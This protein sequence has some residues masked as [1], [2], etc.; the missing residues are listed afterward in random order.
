MNNEK[1]YFHKGVLCR[2]L[3]VVV[4]VVVYDCQ[5]SPSDWKVLHGSSCCKL[6]SWGVC[7]YFLFCCFFFLKCKI[8]NGCIPLVLVLGSVT[9]TP[10]IVVGTTAVPR[11]ILFWVCSYVLAPGLAWWTQVLWSSFCAVFYAHIFE[12]SKNRPFALL[13]DWLWDCVCVYNGGACISD[14]SSWV[15]ILDRF[16]DDWLVSDPFCY[17][18][19]TN[20]WFLLDRFIKILAVF[21]YFANVWLLK[22]VSATFLSC[23]VFVGMFVACARWK[24]LLL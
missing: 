7:F 10:T 3:S 24:W 2:L 22:T 16:F 9:I 11:A 15:I 5:R 4:V 18:P 21:A 8:V 13:S 20:G 14:G 1:N 23:G 17:R 12:V 19:L 6:L